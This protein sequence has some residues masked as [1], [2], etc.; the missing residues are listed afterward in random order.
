MNTV[1]YIQRLFYWANADTRT[2]DMMLFDVLGEDE[3]GKDG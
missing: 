3:N 2:T 1:G